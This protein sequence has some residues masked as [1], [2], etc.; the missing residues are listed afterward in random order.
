MKISLIILSQVILLP[1]V[2]SL[3]H[4]RKGQKISVKRQTLRFLNESHTMNETSIYSTMKSSKEDDKSENKSFKTNKDF[5]VKSYSA[6]ITI[7]DRPLEEHEENL[8]N[9]IHMVKD[10]M[11]TTE[12][13]PLEEHEENLHNLIHMVK[14]RMNMTED[15]PLEEH[16]EN[17]HDLIHMV[18]DR[19]N[20]TEFDEAGDIDS[21]PSSGEVSAAN[22]YSHAS[23]SVIFSTLLSLLV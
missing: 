6:N 17:L 16:E 13:R 20:T 21:A 22:I 10:K 11:N 18:K 1:L 5:N 8:H 19:M 12:D 9:L 4:G 2:L 3:N 23:Y 7:E 15:R 14:E